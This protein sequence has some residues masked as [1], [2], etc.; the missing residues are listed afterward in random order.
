VFANIVL[1]LIVETINEALSQGGRKGIGGLEEAGGASNTEFERINRPGP[2]MLVGMGKDGYNFGW[3]F[4]LRSL[5]RTACANGYC[6]NLYQNGP[7]GPKF[8]CM[9]GPTNPS[10]SDGVCDL[11]RL[12]N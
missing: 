9:W 2:L 5:C 11:Y 10:L 4:F 8:L 3:L 1:M 7:Q 12:R 6:T